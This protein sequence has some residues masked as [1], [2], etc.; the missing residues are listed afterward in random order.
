MSGFFGRLAPD[1]R[2][3]VSGGGAIYGRKSVEVR[4]FPEGR[5]VNE[6]SDFR[7][8]L[9]AL[10]ISHSGKLFAVAGG[11]YGGGEGAVSLW[12]FAEARELGF[13]S[14]G[15]YPI[16][17]LAFSPDDRV[18]AAASEDGFVLLYAVDRIRGPRV[19]KQDSALCGEVM[20]E[21]DRAFIAPISKVP[22]PMGRGFE[23]PWRL[24]VSN[25]EALR[26]AAGDPVVLR[27]WAIESSAATD[28]ARV[29]VFGPL[30]P[31]ER[32]SAAKSDHIIFGHTQN[33]GWDESFV[34]KIYGD[35]TFLATNNSGKCLA[36]GRLD[37]L[38]TDFE[39]LKKRLLS[40]GLLSVPKE[41]L[42]LGADHYG[43]AYIEISTGGAAE[44]R[45]DADD[46]GVLLKGGP[47]KKRE[48]FSR[49][50]RLE[51]KFVNSLLHAGMKP[52]PK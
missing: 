18:L 51:E 39:S 21:G 13:V 4:T 11:T 36:S 32:P 10:D 52:T 3:V 16:M 5:K 44:L 26:D 37:Q 7:N 14:F 40:E 9:F 2:H 12:D 35:G 34:V 47:A 38:K 25:P 29:E 42:T 15:E 17:G 27:D 46:I 24:E 30:L 19:K 49:V 48:A 50:F 20:V 28:R 41:P 1:G 8:G 33:P 23:F 31:R 6:L 43:T 22:T 45:S